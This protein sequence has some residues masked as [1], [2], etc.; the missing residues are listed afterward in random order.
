MMNAR[1]ILEHAIKHVCQDDEILVDGSN[2]TNA[3]FILDSALQI[4]VNET[5][6]A[7]ARIGDFIDRH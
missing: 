7:R 5:K 1:T 2:A 6:L 3:Y 4:V